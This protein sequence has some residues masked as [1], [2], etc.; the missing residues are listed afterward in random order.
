M[1]NVSYHANKPDQ[2]HTASGLTMQ[3]LAAEV[4]APMQKYD[5][6]KVLAL[7]VIGGISEMYSKHA[8]DSAI[9]GVHTD[10]S[11]SIGK[12]LYLIINE[13]DYSYMEVSNAWKHLFTRKMNELK[14]Y[15]MCEQVIENVASDEL[16]AFKDWHF[17]NLAEVALLRDYA[18]LD[19]L[20]NAITQ[21]AT[22]QSKQ[23]NANE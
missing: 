1:N 23:R 21:I 4:N 9:V 13:T 14:S 17:M 18:G 6:Q 22:L 12:M 10:F 8:A 19:G 20:K 2:E 5:L 15:S 7:G 16:S 11:R 3:L